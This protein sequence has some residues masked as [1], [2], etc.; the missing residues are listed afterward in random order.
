[1]VAANIYLNFTSLFKGKLSHGPV[2]N[3]YLFRY[4]QSQYVTSYDD[5]MSQLNLTRV[6]ERD[7]GHYSCHAENKAG[8]VSHA[9][10]MRVFGKS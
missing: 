4:I 5:V 7:G 2:F 10:E 8:S 6:T 9:A 3:S 1:V